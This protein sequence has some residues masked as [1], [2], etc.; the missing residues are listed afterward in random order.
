MTFSL[1]TYVLQL[2]SWCKHKHS[3][4]STIQS[5]STEASLHIIAVRENARRSH[6]LLG[7][8]G[9]CF[10]L[11]KVIVIKYTLFLV[12]AEMTMCRGQWRGCPWRTHLLMLNTNKSSRVRRLVDK[13][14]L[15]EPGRSESSKRSC[16][17]TMPKSSQG[18]TE[19]QPRG[20]VFLFDS[21]SVLC[22]RGA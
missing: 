4:F 14:P 2:H 17:K 18:V 10:W 19:C 21:S 6:P 22:F 9:L 11:W 1:P 12:M 5:T 3:L 15:K 7:Q 16:D 13:L 20:Q 8:D